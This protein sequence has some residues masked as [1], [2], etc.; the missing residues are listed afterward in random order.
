MA[1]STPD[2]V[3]KAC[4][5]TIEDYGAVAEGYARGNMDHD[6]SQN[7]EALMRPLA[8]VG[9]APFDIL[10]VCCAS[11]RDLVTFTRLGHRAVG[12]DGVAA[13]CEM[14]REL[15]GCEVWE[16]DLCAL[17]LPPGRFDGIFCN[18]CLFHLP[19]AA[20]PAALAAL[21][22]ALRPH[23]VLFVSN[24][25]GFGKDKEGWTGGRTPATQSY[26]CWLS[27]ATWLATCEAAGF[28]LIEKFY[29]PPGRPRE[30]QPFLATS[31]SKRAGTQD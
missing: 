10:D 31:W 9:S 25:H 18:A 11:G 12:L 15:S 4:R 7:I 14:S 1:A 23:G 13:F 5:A 27:E 26:V 16:Q 8:R 19:F 6:V 29:R 30:Q 24:A 20:L 21:R 28:E 3:H 2:A 22:R 17:D